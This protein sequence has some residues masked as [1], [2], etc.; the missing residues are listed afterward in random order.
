ML[1]RSPGSKSRRASWAISSRRAA[2]RH[3]PA[4][5][6]TRLDRRRFGADPHLQTGVVADPETDA[7]AQAHGVAEPQP[8]SR[9][10]THA[11]C[12]SEAN[13][14]SPLTPGRPEEARPR[15]VS[16]ESGVEQWKLVGL[17]TRRSSVRIRP[18]QPP[19]SRTHRRAFRSELGGVSR[20]HTTR[21]REAWPAVC[22]RPTPATLSPEVGAC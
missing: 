12:H 21:A 13:A 11:N 17:I 4:G 1:R 10:D 22:R 18:P 16:S 2:L 9:A 6:S 3:L 8:E 19:H 20:R 14:D 5:R 15:A 7:D